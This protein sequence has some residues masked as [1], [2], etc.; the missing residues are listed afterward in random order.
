M[1]PALLAAILIFPLR[2]PPPTPP[3]QIPPLAIAVDSANGYR[4]IL[5]I[6]HVLD[7][8][9]LEQATRSGLPIRLRIRVELWRDGFFDDLEGSDSWTTVLLFEPLDRHYIVRPRSGRALRYTSYRSAR[10]AL[11]TAY[12][13][14]MKPRRS[15]RYYYTATLEVETLSLSDLDE[16]ERWLQGELQPAVSGERSIPGAVA[17]GAKRLMIRVLG[18]PTKHFDARSG[19][20]EI[21]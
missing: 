21:E 15:G 5:R 19:R 17:Q 2:V 9:D 12:P 3:R 18:L 10:L 13:L 6:G 1:T 4:P 16:L 14:T 7:D 11:E 20:F 8:P